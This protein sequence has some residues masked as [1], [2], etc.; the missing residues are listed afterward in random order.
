MFKKD[1]YTQ[2]K[3][4]KWI[5]AVL[6]IIAIVLIILDFAAVID[7]NGENSKW[8][9]VNNVI[10]IIFAVDYFWRLHLAA[11]KRQFVRD[12]IF[13]LLAIIPVG[14]AFSWMKFVQVDNIFLYFRLLRLIRLAGLVGKLRQV[15]H[16]NGILYMLYFTLTFLM[17]GAVAFS[18]TEHVP[19]NKA[20][21]W[22]ITTASTVGY[23]D[24]S[25]QTIVPKS[26]MGQFVVLVMIIIGVGMMGMVSSSLTTYFMKKNSVSTQSETQKS[27]NLILKKLNILE[28]QNQQLTAQ[29]EKMHEQIV[30]LE[31]K[32][33]STE[34]QRFKSWI[35]KHEK[36]D[37]AK[38]D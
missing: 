12:N 21:W 10:L 7:I 6:A 36:A 23:G 11:D 34:W 16:T 30:A 32:Q 22:A 38:N 20:F 19:L 29:N 3:Y 25:A 14:I 18:I 8:F 24:I 4:Y 9:W 1:T 17:L 13:D 35:N 27:L 33:N 28:K 2:T 5:T 31:A 37:E 26:L 15:L